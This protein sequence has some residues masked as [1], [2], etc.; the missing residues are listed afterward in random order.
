MI[1][2]NGSSSQYTCVID[3]LD[4][5]PATNSDNVVIPVNGIVTISAWTT[6]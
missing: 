4:S 2:Q 5:N 6:P 1:P 3:N